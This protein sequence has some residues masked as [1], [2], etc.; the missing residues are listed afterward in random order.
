MTRNSFI[1]YKSWWNSIAGLP[2]DIRLEVYDNA[3]RYAFGETVEESTMAAQVALDFIKQDLDR[4]I[5]NYA[6]MVERNRR[7][8]AK[9]GRPKNNPNNP[10]NPKNPPGCLETRRNP[11]YDYDDNN[12]DDEYDDDDGDEDT[13]PVGTVVVDP[14]NCIVAGTGW[15]N[16]FEEY[17]AGLRKCYDI[18][19]NDALWLAERR[20]FNPR[21]DVLK[22]LKKV[23]VEYW[24]TKAG[25]KNKKESRQRSI[26]WKTTLTKSIGAKF[27][28]VYENGT[29]NNHDDRS[30]VGNEF[31]ESLLRDI[32]AI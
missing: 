7:N 17:L 29:G 8:G 14:Q 22:T 10:K 25:W 28:H 27:N 4:S 11:D 1:F 23:C 13:T 3:I 32:G 26:D 5:E 12:D 2:G 9:G 21:V 31:R 15:R 18:L 6:N 20:E 30:T 19:R 24:G 16:D